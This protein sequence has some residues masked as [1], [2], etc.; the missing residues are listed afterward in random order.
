MLPVTDWKKYKKDKEQKLHE[1]SFK[2]KG[3]DFD[4]FITVL[5][6]MYLF[7]KL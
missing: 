7:V 6:K 1:M 2:E 4:A 3:N 5:I